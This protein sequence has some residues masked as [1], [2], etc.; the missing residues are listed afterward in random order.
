M[1]DLKFVS[2]AGSLRGAFLEKGFSDEQPVSKITATKK[3]NLEN[4]G[5]LGLQRSGSGNFGAA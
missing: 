1:E 5:I 4:L 3:A 2:G